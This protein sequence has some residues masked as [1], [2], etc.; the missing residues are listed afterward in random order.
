[1]I[2]FAKLQD[3][4]PV[5]YLSQSDLLL[6]RDVLLLDDISQDEEKKGRSLKIAE[7]LDEI[8]QEPHSIIVFTK[9]VH[10]GEEP[11]VE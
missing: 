1:V 10:S 3:E 11:K 6:V 9:D 8:N 2:K 5:I 7:V 4:T